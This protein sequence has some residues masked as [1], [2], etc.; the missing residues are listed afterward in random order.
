MKGRLLFIA[1]SAFLLSSVAHAQRP[2]W[3]ESSIQTKPGAR[4]WWLGSAVD[5]QNLEFLMDEYARTGIGTLEITPIYGIQQ[6]Y[7]KPTDPANI[8]FLSSDWMNMLRKAEEIG[9]E[10]GIQID[11]NMGTGWPFGGLNVSQSDA[12][13]KLEYYNK[14]FTT[15]AESPDI[16]YELSPASGSTLNVVM[17]FP[18]RIAGADTVDVTSY[19][20]GNTLKWTPGQV[21]RWRIIA[22]YNGHTNQMVKRAAPGGE[23][24]VLDHLNRDAVDRYIDNFERVF[25]RY[26]EIYP[27]TFFND[28][29]EIFNADWSPHFFEE[30]EARRGYKLQYHL[31][32]LL[33]LTADKNNQVRSD[34]R[35]TMGDMYID[36]F[37]KPW[38]EFAHRHGVLTRNQSHG[39]PS[40][41]LDTYASVDIPEIEG[42]GKTPMAIQGLRDDKG[43]YN[44]NSSDFATL[45][46]ASSA[47][48]VTGKPLASSETFTW[49]T[50]HFRTSLSQMKPEMDLMFL[51]GVNRMFFHGTTYSPQ[52]APW[53]GY[54]F[55]ASIDMSPTNSIWHDASEFM[56]YVDRCQ[57]FLQMGN[58]DND[59]LLY[60]PCY[61][62]W[63]QVGSTW[64]R[65]CAISEFAS[66]YGTLDR[67]AMALDQM[68]YG[69][70]YVSDR[71]IQNL[72]VEDGMI[73]TEGG[74]RYKALQIPTASY[75]PP[76]TTEK[77]AQLQEQGA[78]IISVSS[79]EQTFNDVCK[80]EPMRKS[81][82]RY[83]RRSNDNGH[84]YFITNLTS[85]DVDDYFSLAV[86]F[87]TAALFNPLDGSIQRALVDS[88][89][90][91]HLCLRSGESAILQTYDNDPFGLITGYKEDLDRKYDQVTDIAIDQPWTLTF[92]KAKLADNSDFSNIYQLDK[93]QTWE[94]LD[95]NTAQLMGTGIYET[96]VTLEDDQVVNTPAFWMGDRIKI[97]L[98]DVRESARVYVND[99]YVGCAWSVPF[100]LDCTSCLKP[101]E[102]KIRIEVTNLPANR[103]RQMDKNKVV[104]RIFDDIN[105]SVISGSDVGTS[106]T[107]FAGWALTPS[108]L[109]SE[110]KLRLYR[111]K[112]EASPIKGDVNRDG[113]VDISDIV[114]IIN[115]IAG[116]P[117]Y[118]DTS[119]VN[120]DNSIDISDIVA[121]INIIAGK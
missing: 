89:G 85:D 35:E 40:N 55:Y 54:K 102:N 77:I 90:K 8:L 66:Q 56:A 81:G 3:P 46:L 41:L 42:Y 1:V 26:G 16:V 4:W 28:S 78:N 39:S 68:G 100:E 37:V 36:N 5:E 99:V 97:L 79:D 84:H 64:L 51:A 29:Y 13:G 86:D 107:S 33:R 94:K 48:H 110:V 114:A 43:F 9:A 49:F 98:G 91:V 34:Y 111:H 69:T 6:Q 117:T 60:F 112:G 17:A 87:Q 65:L 67:I 73:V 31:Q 38:T 105:F 106:T 75:M 101:G 83:I 18:Q 63:H 72:K 15:N 53:P 116:N 58:P 25:Q 88:E 14:D 120:E 27:A 19:M 113:D 2:Q 82:L 12:A 20:D 10:K 30:F 108:G 11:M 52:S 32:E 71:M 92:D 115:T 93:A 7:R 59:I 76:E 57:S 24:Y 45:K 80:P 74:V 96:T 44:T 118:L 23:G 109:N 47:A 95:A 104:W 70:D 62:S 103:I 61:Y 121:V 50:E 21:G 22:I 119:D